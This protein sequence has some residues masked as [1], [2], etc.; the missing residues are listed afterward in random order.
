MIQGNDR[1]RIALFTHSTNPRGG[2]VHALQLAEALHDLGHHAVLHVPDTTGRGLFRGPRC[3]VSYIP[4]ASVIGGLAE[5]VKQRVD[6]I[7][8]F[9]EEAPATFDLYHAQDPISANALATLVQRGVIPAYVRTVHHLDEWA[10][11]RLEQYQDRSVTTAQRCFCVSNMWREI[12]ATRYGIDS[13]VVPNGVDADHFTHVQS[14]RDGDVAARYRL[15]GSPV[16]LS[17]GG[18]ESRKNSIGILRAF[19]SILAQFPKAQLVI[20]GGASLLDHSDYRREFEKIA[21]DAGVWTD[22]IS[23]TANASAFSPSPG[24][25]GEGWGGGGL[26]RELPTVGDSSLPSSPL[27]GPPPEYQ[28]RGHERSPTAGDEGRLV[29]TGVVDNANMPSLYRLADALV[30][31]SVKEGFGLAVLEAMASGTPVICPNQPPFTE[32]LTDGDALFVDPYN[33]DDVACAL[34]RVTQSTVTNALRIAGQ[35]VSRRFSWRASAECHVK[36]YREELNHAGNA[37]SGSL[38]R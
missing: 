21:R 19:V 30:F 28:G 23:G 1:L 2:V 16:L 11:I 29:I 36:F 15:A 8:S 9:L 18:I 22:G 32:Y 35:A 31:P 10:D 6:E 7:V 37:I 4:A 38:A 5:L 12:L 26:L 3:P 27:P 33:V 25:P 14:S 24:T 13:R 20:A 34:L 17:V